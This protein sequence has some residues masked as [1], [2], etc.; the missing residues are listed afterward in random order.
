MAPSSAA[1]DSA[2]AVTSALVSG[3]VT[4]SSCLVCPASQFRAGIILHPH[5]HEV[6]LD[7]PS[8]SWALGMI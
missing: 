3:L 5:R 1:I 6:T 7:A 4:R 2:S 8:E